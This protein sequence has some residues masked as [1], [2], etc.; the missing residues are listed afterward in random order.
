MLTVSVTTVYLLTL[1][2]Q[3]NSDQ[4]INTTKHVFIIPLP[5]LDSL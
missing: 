5:V 2:I 3:D 4:P 1:L